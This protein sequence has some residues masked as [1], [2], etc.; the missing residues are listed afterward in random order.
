[1]I[2][3]AS[4]AAAVII[5]SGLTT[6]LT[7]QHQLDQ[8]VG[9]RTGSAER[10]RATLMGIPSLDLTKQTLTEMAKADSTAVVVE[11]DGQAG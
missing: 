3:L 9:E 11:I 7:V 1:M 4:V 8:R 10:I 6:V 2:T 5:I